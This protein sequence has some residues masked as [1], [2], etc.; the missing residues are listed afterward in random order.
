MPDNFFPPLPSKD[1]GFSFDRLKI[2]L[3][4]QTVS[5]QKII[6]GTLQASMVL[7]SSNYSA[8]SAG[9]QIDG[10]GNAEFNDIVVRGDIESGNWDGSSPANLATV[11]AGASVGFY[12]DSSVGSAQFEGDIFV[13]GGI[14]MQD[15]GAT[16]NH[17]SW[18]DLGG[19]TNSL[20]GITANQGVSLELG[21]TDGTGG[22]P[23]IDFH[24][25]DDVDFNVR[26]IVTGA[27]GE[28]A[29]TLAVEAFQVL[30]DDD[31][32]EADPT[33]T[34]N[35]DDDTGM[36]RNA[37]DQLAFTCGNSRELYLGQNLF[38]AQSI[39]DATTGAAVNVH[40]AANAQVLRNTS[41]QK[42]KTRISYNVDYLADYALNP[43]KFYRKDDK[44]WFYG[45]VADDIA[46]QDPLMGVYN[47]D[48]EVEGFDTTM[49]MAVMAAKINRLEALAQ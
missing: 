14:Q 48:D 12:L 15:G 32:T 34:F 13:G 27:A 47:E 39:Y 1:D 10:D 8:G 43:A 7:S 42:Y 21:R 29:G 19:A 25:G 23:F 49:V 38:V 4:S 17:I 9:W 35:G 31:G 20:L 37:A 28:G 44:R 30:Y 46:E 40:I 5:F 18:P 26:L 41:A 33:I 22:T 16:Q 36:Y 11:D 2:W 3:A 45:F 24:T 6:T